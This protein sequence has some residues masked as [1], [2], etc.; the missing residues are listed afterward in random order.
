MINIEVHLPPAPQIKLKK[1]VVQSLNIL[2][3]IKR[4]V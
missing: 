2:R 3:K 4:M 1:Q